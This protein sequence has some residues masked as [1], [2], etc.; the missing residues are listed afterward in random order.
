M[1]ETFS[2]RLIVLLA[3]L[4]AA[5]PARVA[6]AQA[7]SAVDIAQA[8]ELYNQAMDLRDKGDVNGSLDK[9]RAAHALAATPITGLE[10][11]RTYAQVG[12]LIEAREALLG[13]GRIPIQREETPRSVTARKQAADLAEQIRPRIP[14]LVVHIIG[15]SAESVAVAVD[16]AA[17]PT[18][19]LAAPRLL[20]P[21]THRVVATTTSGGNAETKVEL[22][23]GEARTVELKI[24]LTGGSAQTA[25]T[26]ATPTP[27]QPPVTPPVTTPPTVVGDSGSGS[28]W[29]GLGPLVYAGFG[30]AGA[31]I[32]TGT[33]TGLVSMSK[34]SSVQNA[35]QGTTCP[36]SVDSDLQTGR[37][38]GNVATISFAVAGV[39][40]VVGVIGLLTRHHQEQPATTSWVSP[41]VGPGSA[42]VSGAF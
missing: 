4:A 21:G 3:A 8:R 24:V 6:F 36:T 7:R 37:T 42:G 30:L 17:V 27:A 41:W 22:K 15:V 16:G 35:C 2:R 1:R 32:I 19:A 5:A 13:V 33:A 20:N 38:M 14:S 29:G 11:G 9:F 34:A 25:Q 26:P 23:E 18:E 10:L 28:S 12:K 40:A 31:G 39:G